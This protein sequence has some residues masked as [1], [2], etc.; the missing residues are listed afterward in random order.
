M[1][2]PGDDVV[3]DVPPDYVEP[4]APPAENPGPAE[5]VT[6]FVV[7]PPDT[8]DDGEPAPE[9]SDETDRPVE[10]DLDVV[11]PTLLGMPDAPEPEPI[12]TEFDDAEDDGESL[13]V[14]EPDL[15]EQDDFL[16][17]PGAAT[18]SAVDGRIIL[19]APGVELSLDGI[20]DVSIRLGDLADLVIGDLTGTDIAQDTVT[21]IGNDGNNKLYAQALSNSRSVVQALG[22]NDYLGGSFG[23]DDL[24]G[25]AGNDAL[26]GYLG[27]DLLDGGTG[28]DTAY[29]TTALKGVEVRLYTTDWQDTVGEG[30]DKLVGIE[31]LVGSYRD[32]RLWGSAAANTL[33]GMPGNDQL[34]GRE[35][36]DLLDG[37]TGDD[38]LV[39]GAGNDSLRGGAGADLLQGGSDNDTLDGGD[40][41]DILDGGSG[42]DTFSGGAGIDFASFES[43]SSGV[44]VSLADNLTGRIKISSVRYLAPAPQNTGDGVD[45]INRD[46]EGL[47]GSNFNDTL[48]GSKGADFLRG[49][50]GNDVILSGLGNDFLEGGA[51][52]DE[53]NGGDGIDTADYRGATA[54]IWADIGDIDGFDTKNAGIDTYASI[55]NLEGSSYNDRLWGNAQGNSINGGNGDDIVDGREGDDTLYGG[56]GR[57][58]LIGNL[59][60]DTLSGGNSSDLLE[61]REG[62]DR[63]FGGNGNDNLL[64]GDGKDMLDGGSGNDTLDGG[65]G[66]DIASYYNVPGYVWVD[67]RS[68]VAQDTKTAGMDTLLNIEDVAGSKFD[69]RI[70]GNS[71]ANQLLGMDGNDKIDGGDG[72]DLIDGGNGNDQLWGGNG[73]DLFLGSNGTDIIRGGDGIDTVDYSRFKSGINIDLSAPDQRRNIDTFHDIENIIGS[74]NPNDGF[75]RD[76]LRGNDADNIIDGRGGYDDIYGMGGNDRL[77][78]G[79]GDDKLVGGEGDDELNGGSGIDLLYGE[80]GND[81]LHSSDGRDLLDGGDGN[82]TF[83]VNYA[84]PSTYELELFGGNGLDTVDYSSS[85]YRVIADLRTNKIT[86]YLGFADWFGTEYSV[87]DSINSIENVTGSTGNDVLDGHSATNFLNG[88]DG[89]DLINGRGGSDWLIG[90]AGNDVITLDYSAT[91]RGIYS[92]GSGTDKLVIN[93]SAADLSNTTLLSDIAGFGKLL[94]QSAGGEQTQNFIFTAQ[95]QTL[96]LNGIEQLEVTV[97]GVVNVAPTLNSAL[98]VNENSTTVGTL[99]MNDSQRPLPQGFIDGGA[100]AARFT[101]NSETGVLQFV[102]APDFEAPTDADG[103]NVYEL[104]V[105]A[106]DGLGGW[107][108]QAISVSVLDTNDAVAVNAAPV[109][110]FAGSNLLNNGSF[111]Q[112]AIGGAFVA[113]QTSGLNGWTIASGNIDIIRSLWPAAEGAQSLDLNGSGPGSIT[114]SFATRAGMPYRVSFELSKNSGEGSTSATI[115]VAA[116]GQS[117]NF[118]FSGASTSSN[119]LWDTRSYSFVADNGSAT[120]SIASQSP[121]SSGPALDNVRVW[122]EGVA[123]RAGTTVAVQGLQVSDAD[124]GSAPLTLSL[125][126]SHGTLALSSTANLTVVDGNG[127]DGTLVVSG[128]QTALNAMLASALSYTASAAFT[129]T[130]TLNV[131]VNDN[132]NT[133]TTGPASATLQVPVLVERASVTHQIGNLVSN[134]SFEAPAFGTDITTLNAGNGSLAGWTIASGSVDVIKSG[135]WQAAAGSQSLDLN[136]DSPASIQQALATTGGKQYTALFAQSKNTFPGIASEPSVIEVSADGGPANF[137]FNQSVSG[138]NMNWTQQRYDFTAS[139]NSTLLR[140]ASVSPGGASGPAL[141]HVV[142]VERKTLSDFR[143]GSGGDVLNFGSLLDSLQAPRGGTAAFDQGWLDFDTSSGSTVI[144]LDP[145]GGGNS[146]VDFI[147]LTGVVLPENASANY[148]V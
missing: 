123:A 70:W 34:D 112:P 30:R 57:D 46:I 145:N 17:G 143:V 24:Y 65:A 79:N 99:Q 108:R 135:F 45:K 56:E 75:N 43:A 12:S 113:N 9:F 127:S 22:G 55:E 2:E 139:D 130:D 4:P 118:T 76:R 61:G 93:L 47:I 136:G 84:D 42:N 132:G 68:S 6:D 90:G 104:T 92:G 106:G 33:Q 140:F 114:Q 97:D 50:A 64:G 138:A 83:L 124:A 126:V 141:D 100:D 71:G 18:L 10:P 105:L 15:A 147:T 80:A 66:S 133:G 78:G 134:G 95:T 58:R 11:D 16:P 74:N 115:S 129:G 32:D 120:L 44:T 51:G 39:G 77:F 131:T 142:V 119:M 52:D 59:G 5:D 98:S 128:S 53:L 116:D 96:T 1:G 122:A 60:N 94:F 69:D 54:G 111:E 86:R 20:E 63:L 21:V 73:N 88:G 82:D 81:T 117:Q 40:D 19:S 7:A 110:R 137:S 13:L 41:N 49:G 37:G 35:G 38:R 36:D 103:N 26:L 109:L 27:D 89:N 144:R 107:T 91:A 31:N 14:P 87:Q 48:T 85:S 72:N 8:S 148:V 23:P 125:S 67:L 29:Y 146:Y 3:D 121:T 102:T 101:L 25:G 62:D 28:I